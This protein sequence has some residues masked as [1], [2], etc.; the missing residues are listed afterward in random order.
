MS[1]AR[2]SAPEV[3]L[4]HSAASAPEGRHVP[5]LSYVIS[6]LCTRMRGARGCAEEIPTTT[7]LMAVTVMTSIHDCP[8]VHSHDDKNMTSPHHHL[9]R[10]TSYVCQIIM[11][12]GV[13]KSQSWQTRSCITA[14]FLGQNHERM[15]DD[16]C[17]KPPI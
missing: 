8:H 13:T 2:P 14:A 1:T 4:S 7:H 6:E 5:G 3:Q 15:Q 11:D 16:V 17:V 9:P 10:Q 12:T